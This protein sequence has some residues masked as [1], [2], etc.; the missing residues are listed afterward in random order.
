MKRFSLP[1]LFVVALLA[2]TAGDVIDRIAAVVN[3]DV[4]LLSEV[5][6][7]MF[8]LQAQGQLQGQDST[9]VAKA[10]REILDRL[11]EERL[12]VQRAKSQGIQVDQQEVTK[13]VNDAMTKVKDRFPSLEAY[14]Q[15]L[16][17]EGI[18]ENMLRERYQTDITQEFLGQRIVGKEVRSK[19]QVTSDDVEKY[20]KENK[21]QLPRKPMEIKLAHLLIYP[22]S[23]A[24]E[25]AARKRIEDARARI[26]GGE[27][28]A[29]VA[30]EVSDD[31]T[32][33]KGGEL[34]WFSPGDLDP[35]FENAVDSLA[36][37]AISEPVRTRYGYHLI[38]VEERDG[39][40]FRVR[41]ILALVEAGQQDLDRA[42]ARADSALARIRGGAPWDSVV[43]Q[44]S[45]DATTR[46][47]GGDLGWTPMKFLVPAVG[48][49]VESLQVGEVSGVVPSDR[50]FHIFKVE[51]RRSG[52]DYTFDEIKDQLRSYLEQKKLEDAYDKWMAGIRD[53][54]YVEI[55]AWDR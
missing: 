18:S 30:K 3:D 52:E 45:D 35:D 46:D 22:V 14:R 33:T 29:A 24:K 41:H 53:S 26:V 50:G 43:R 37:N 16:A 8:I 49:A 11:I 4:I 15:A 17:Q 12:V 21:D 28:F 38:Q 44:M 25:N 27:D 1:I 34:G 54:A 23:P 40:R 2:L 20:F 32:K 36:V 48:A 6:E 7:K 39:Q 51:N 5:E 47:Q 13:Q 31:P 19:V 10:R 9:Q 55:K 42:R